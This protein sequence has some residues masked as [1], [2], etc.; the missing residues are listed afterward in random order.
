MSFNVVILSARAAN[1]VPCARS[2]LANEP[3]L[4][5]QQIIVVDDGARAEAEPQLPGVR[6]IA[7]AKPFIF[8]RNA[9][10]GIQA[11]DAD[12]FILLNDDARLET[13]GGFTSLARQTL[14]RPDL[15][16]CSA[17]IH[18]FIGNPR[19]ISPDPDAQ[20]T[21]SLRIEPVTL[22]FV[23]VCF[24]KDVYAALGPLDE[25]FAGYGH[26][27][28]DYCA[29]ALVAGFELGIWDGCV[30]EHGVLPSTFR[31]SDDWR[32]RSA[33]NQRRYVQK[34]RDLARSAD[35]PVDLIYLADNRAEFTRAT[36]GSLLRTT[37]WTLVRELQIYDLSTVDGALTWLET[38]AARAPVPTRFVA[39][40]F[41]GPA[42]ALSHAAAS[43]DAP[44]LARVDNDAMVVP[45]WTRQCLGLLE[46]ERVGQARALQARAPRATPLQ[47][48]C[49]EVGLAPPA[50]GD[51]RP[52]VV[53]A[54]VAAFRLGRLPY[55]PWAALADE[56]VE[57]GWQ[58]LQARYDPAA[59]LWHWCW[60]DLTPASSLVRPRMLVALRIKNEAAW[61]AEVLERALDVSSL[62]YVFDDHSTDG[63]PEICRS[64][65]ERVRLFPSPFEGLDE[66]RDK[67]YLFV[68]VIAAR[69]DWV[70]WI[71]GDEVF[72]RASA[73]KLNQ[74]IEAA[75]ADVACYRLRIAYLWDDPGQVRTDGIW[76]RFLRPTLFRLQGQPLDRLYFQTTANGGNLHCGNIP[77]GLVGKVVPLDV[78][79]KHYGYL[80]RE[81]RLA[82]YA[83]Y[84]RIDPDNEREDYYRHLAE[85]PGA[86]HAPGPPEFAAWTE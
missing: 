13:P 81:H 43:T 14:S 7:G 78:R 47:T 19:Q 21:H 31:T 29:R 24:S 75:P 70:L 72:E 18:G 76:G 44:I 3:D 41:D 38:E 1:L 23:C 26:D 61:L 33:E 34:W 52:L 73:E 69:P 30:V 64:F 63:T 67:N 49:V 16:V 65:G 66:A 28:N 5:P 48:G 71:D 12:A 56:Y 82:K 35:R 84:T 11:A 27:D 57:R 60:P 36:F 55:D 79:L 86:R 25:R 80:W 54:G 51:G 42:A 6:W 59:S 50:P 68:R 45:G 85:I 9:N 8:S 2:V 53:D 32:A 22:A 17:A 83:W 74:A 4:L 58:P 15:G 39:G 77:T 10:L 40:R 46:Q 37:N 20:S 62:V